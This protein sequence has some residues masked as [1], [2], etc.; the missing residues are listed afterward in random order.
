MEQKQEQ[1]EQERP[2][3]KYMTFL[4][5]LEELR[6]CLLITFGTVG[7]AT[8][9]AFFFADWILALFQRPVADLLKLHSSSFT[10]TFMVSL[11]VSAVTGLFIGFPVVLHQLWRFVSPGLYG[12]EKKHLVPFIF[13]AWACF[14]IGGLFGY[15]LMIPAMLTMMV[16]F[17]P[18]FLEN[19]WFIGKYVNM[20]LTMILACGLLFDVP[21]VIILL[22]KLGLINPR[23]LAKYRGYAMLLSF[24]VGAVLTPPDPITQTM[25]A[26]PLYLLFEA[27]IWITL[28]LGYGKK[29]TK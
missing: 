29:E 15:F 13:A 18:E 3:E 19:T 27:S 11:K 9:L 17:T 5:H 16:R 12:K 28:L 24:V 6:K 14:I 4:E 8:I 23:K 1:G 7:G 22:A 25:L 2:D 10:E 20:L 21:L 26:L